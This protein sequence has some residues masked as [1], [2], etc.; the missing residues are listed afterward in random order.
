MTKKRVVDNRLTEKEEQELAH[1]YMV[2]KSA[3]ALMNYRVNAFDEDGTLEVVDDYGRRSRYNGQKYIEDHIRYF[4]KKDH[5]VWYR[6]CAKLKLVQDE[7]DEKFKDI[8]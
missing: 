4:E 1:F 5:P 6:L 8:K 7:Y 2:R 3:R